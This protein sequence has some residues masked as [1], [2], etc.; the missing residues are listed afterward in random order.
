M[1]Q[2]KDEFYEFLT[3]LGESISDHQ[4]GEIKH[5]LHGH[6]DKTSIVKIQ[7]SYQ[8]IKEL[9]QKKL[10][11]KNKLEFLKKLIQG[12]TKNDKLLRIIESFRDQKQPTQGTWIH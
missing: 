9:V 6:M 3:E 1:T 11:N 7:G 10:V 8:L 12:T 5:S 4:L 2:E